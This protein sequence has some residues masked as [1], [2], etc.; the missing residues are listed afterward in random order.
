MFPEIGMECFIKIF[1]LKLITKN[2]LPVNGM[3]V[4]RFAVVFAHVVVAAVALF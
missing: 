1:N 3:L 2:G 4:N